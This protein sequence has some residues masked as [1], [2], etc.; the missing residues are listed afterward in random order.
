VHG[1]Y[2]RYLLFDLAASR[3]ESLPLPEAEARAYLGGAGLATRWLHRHA[4][5]RVEPFAPENPL[6]L[7]SCP[8]VDTGLTT[9]SRACFA[10]RSPQ[11]RLL[12]E[13]L[14]SS[15]FA[16]ALKR[17]GWDGLV[18]TGACD[19]LSVLV[20][21]EEE[22]RVV[23]MPE[24]AGKT[25]SET[26]NA[27]RAALGKGFQVAAVGPAGEH[28]VRYATIS[29]DGRHAGRTGLGAVMG[30]KGLKAIAI[31][32]DRRAAIHDPEALR[33][34]ALALRERSLGPDTAKYRLL[35][36]AGNLLTFDRLGVLP[37][38]NF[39]AATFA[40]AERLT[41]ERLATDRKR[42]RTGCA[43][44]T[45]GCEHRYVPAEGE[46]AVRIE[47]ESLFALG[48]LLGIDDPAAV[49]RAAR[50][51]DEYGL[52]TLSFGGT[53]AWAMEAVERG[54]LG[55]RPDG[56]D[57]RFGNGAALIEAVPRAARR[58]GFLGELLAEGSRR[59]AA[60]LG[61]GSEAWAMHVKGLELP[62]YEPRALK[63]LA[64]GL[65]V[66]SRGACHNRSS[67]YDADFSSGAGR[68][69]ADIPRGAEA[70]ASEDRAAVTDS[71]ILC[72]FIRRCFDD[73]YGETAHLLHL[74]AGWDTDAEE[75]RRTGSRIITLKRLYNQ[76]EGAARADDT[77]PPRLLREAVSTGPGEGAGITPE[78]LDRMLDDY[79]RAR[80]WN[81]DG[82]VPNS[83][84]RHALQTADAT[85][86][87]RPV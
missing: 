75:L 54:L 30:S 85:T 76:R 8:L 37:T 56:I 7:A 19:R 84:A 71:L 81:A 1:Y 64:L 43:A 26:E 5:A 68:L 17:S 63:T 15:H 12:G 40:G 39:Q 78:E 36:T 24:L 62:G 67:A 13:S 10:A 27:V 50:L 70:A 20:V 82:T 4:P 22:A 77:L 57:L 47:Y 11:T 53:L 58:E 66:G 31:K 80:G 16:I 60:H 46:E 86:E 14:I 65:A 32:G 21:D 51:C 52:D 44:C 55:P 59:A 41:G 83:L 48:P 2:G 9:T 74:L 69:R 72:K 3:G 61:G 33:Q 79:Y 25:T 87:A 73:F 49:L 42:E 35:G 28:R 38:R 23:S 6:V 34:A 45:I 18:L 29:H